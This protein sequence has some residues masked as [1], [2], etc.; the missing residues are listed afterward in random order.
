MVS[1]T[2][3][4]HRIIVGFQWDRKKTIVTLHVNR[5]VYWDFV[6]NNRII[7]NGKDKAIKT[8]TSFSTTIA[9][10]K[11]DMWRKHF[12]RTKCQTTRYINKFNEIFNVIVYTSGLPMYYPMT[13]VHPFYSVN[14]YYQP[15]YYLPQNINLGYMHT[16][17]MP[18]SVLSNTIDI[19]N[20]ET[21]RNIAR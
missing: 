6:S 20:T 10:F 13:G 17:F 15:L 16:N 2:W 14:P 8:F 5:F 3:N 12:H 11:Y 9:F 1:V 19:E 18:N 4:S 7:Y 21:K